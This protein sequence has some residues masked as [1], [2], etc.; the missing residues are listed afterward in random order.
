MSI[1]FDERGHH[2]H[3]IAGLVDVDLLDERLR[4]GE[5]LVDGRAERIELRR[6]HVQRSEQVRRR[7]A[8]AFDLPHELSAGL[9]PKAGVETK[10]QRD[11][12][13]RR[14]GDA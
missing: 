10:Q 9:L 7:S 11:E 1:A 6:Q 14:S 13:P 4:F 8:R 2:Q 3:R 5:R 12:Q